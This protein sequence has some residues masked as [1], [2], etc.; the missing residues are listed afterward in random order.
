MEEISFSE[1]QEVDGS[2]E[3]AF[4]DLVCLL[5]RRQVEKDSQQRFYN[6]NG[7]GGDGG[8]ECYSTFPNGDEFGWQAKFFLQSLNESSRWNQLDKSVKAALKFHDSLVKY[9]ICVPRILA[10]GRRDGLKKTEMDRWREHVEHWKKT[11]SEKSMNVEFVLWDSSKLKELILEDESIRDGITKQWFS[12]Q[13]LSLS[14]LKK[15]CAL[16]EKS[17]G[18]RYSE[19]NNID[20]PIEKALDALAL[21]DYWS[22]ETRRRLHKFIEIVEIALRWQ[23]DNLGSTLVD[24]TEVHHNLRLV[25]N[26]LL[27]FEMNKVALLDNREII[28]SI[29]KKLVEDVQRLENDYAKNTHH[30]DDAGN[31]SLFYE[32]KRVLSAC[33]DMFKMFSSTNFKAASKRMLLITG[34]AGS[35]KSHL[36]CG[37]SKKQLKN[38]YPV[39]FVLGQHFGGGNPLDFIADQIGID[40]TTDVLPLLETFGELNDNRVLI[41]IDAL[42]EGSGSHEWKN[43]IIRFIEQC[44]RYN[45]VALVMSCRDTYEKVILPDDLKKEYPFLTHNG[46]AGSRQQAVRKYLTSYDIEIPDVP[47]LTDEFSNPLFLRIVCQTMANER[48]HEFPKVNLKF[49]DIFKMYMSNVSKIVSDKLNF[50]SPSIVKGALDQFS[51]KLYPK[52]MNGVPIEEAFVLFKYFDS[53]MLNALLSEG[54]LVQEPGVNNG[55]EV[56]KF[57]FQR[58]SDFYVAKKLLSQ[59]STLDQLKIGFLP[60]NEL[61]K[62]ILG[63]ISGLNN[64]SH[65]LIEILSIEIPNKFNVE[66]DTL[67]PW[68]NEK[69]KNTVFTREEFNVDF[70]RLSVQMRNSDC[71]NEQTLMELNHLFASEL[72]RSEVWEILLGLSTEA[73]HPW[74]AIFLDRNLRKFS[75][76]NRDEV[77]SSYTAVNDGYEKP[78]RKIID[79][80]EDSQLT[81]VSSDR[82]KLVGMTL[83]WVTTTVNPDLRRD[84]TKALTKVLAK[85]T[86]NIEY[87][88]KKYSNIDDAFLVMS[89]YGA[90]YGSLLISDITVLKDAIRVIPWEQL[91]KEQHSN[92]VVRDYLSGIYEYAKYQGIS[93][94]FDSV[95]YPF[96]NNNYLPDLQIPSEKEIEAEG[97]EFSSI[98]R[99]VLTGIADFGNYVMGIVKD[100]SKYPSSKIGHVMTEGELSEQ[101]FG[102]IIKERPDLSEMFFKLKQTLNSDNIE[103]SKFIPIFQSAGDGTDS[104]ITGEDHSI[105]QQRKIMDKLSKDQ[106]ILFKEAVGQYESNQCISFDVKGAQR[107]V[108]KRTCD[109]GWT[110][111]Q[112]GEF[113]RAYCDRFPRQGRKVE[114]IGKKYQWISFYEFLAILADQY[115]YHGSYNYD[116]KTFSYPECY[117]RKF[118]PTIGNHMGIDSYDS[119]EN[120]NHSKW[121]AMEYKLPSVD[122]GKQCKDWITNSSLFPKLEERIIYTENNS[123]WLSLFELPTWSQKGLSKHTNFRAKVWYRV[124]AIAVTNQDLMS[125]KKSVKCDSNLKTPNLAEFHNNEYRYFYLEYPWRNKSVE[126]NNSLDIDNSKVEYQELVFRYSWES[127]DQEHTESRSESILLPSK[128]LIN[129]LGLKCDQKGRWYQGSELVCFDPSATFGGESK[130]LIKKDII[131]KFLKKENYNLV[132]LIGG[133]KNINTDSQGYE[134]R[135][136]DGLFALENGH[137]VG[138]SWQQCE[139]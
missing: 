44:R 86:E 99:S 88:I 134:S 63:K 127:A 108:F 89:L 123:E 15:L 19:E 112:F 71:F 95:E 47:F 66:I 121:N 45:H 118:D 37:F 58:I 7:S 52:E 133:E 116:S 138:S 124:N 84:A 74:N 100:W 6:N 40:N 82:L 109:L 64:W 115:L 125:L 90:V 42:N 2:K 92:I 55:Q 132:W 76:N 106:K 103:N 20:L 13:F 35:G 119:L 93:I 111:S 17:L 33:N 79:W 24:I 60:E 14:S 98:K 85:G 50:P 72:Y 54:I 25:K 75:L 110:S 131:Q 97:E 39:I 102:K 107:W 3:A 67:I 96:Y 78:I 21:N 129:G 29:L 28:Q 105:E 26:K 126:S 10:D 16:S 43:Q 87:F 12:K 34:K 53:D 48:I 73:N 59:Y 30:Y 32:I 31:D 49:E 56:I 68:E 5:A 128:F 4:E 22:S 101:K 94:H 80:V 91:V 57:T 120:K 41:I 70:F 23:S 139:K 65:G 51:K 11:A 137:I 27:K 61:G 104:L 18:K 77:W 69:Y 130:L 135:E 9:Y 83:L 36:L 122:D 46:F 38:K 8:V 114:R 1:I 81:N 117:S 136:F 62:V 113:E